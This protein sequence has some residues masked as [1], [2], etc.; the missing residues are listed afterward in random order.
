MTRLSK[1]RMD[2]MPPLLMRRVDGWAAAA[3]SVPVP[4]RAQAKEL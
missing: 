1:G 3:A 4:T 2:R